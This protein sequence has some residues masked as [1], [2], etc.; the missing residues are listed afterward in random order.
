MTLL[1]MLWRSDRTRK[2]T[3]RDVELLE[4]L[5]REN[6]ATLGGEKTHTALV[7]LSRLVGQSIGYE[8]LKSTEINYDEP[9]FLDKKGLAARLQCNTRTIE[10]L[11]FE[12]KI[13]YIKL[14]RKLVRFDWEKVK[15]RLN[16]N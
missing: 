7:A 4:N 9:G 6:E 1:E 13:P 3:Q 5:I 12:R 14:G 2:P 16:S 11:M 15:T 10:N 8:G